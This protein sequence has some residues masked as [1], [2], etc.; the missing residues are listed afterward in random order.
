MTEWKECRDYLERQHAL[1]VNRRDRDQGQAISVGASPASVRSNLPK[2]VDG[3]VRFALKAIKRVA[4]L[5][6]DLSSVP[7]AQM[8]IIKVFEE[9]HRVYQLAA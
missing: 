3:I 2:D 1:I 7:Q 4:E 6:K 5:R 8:K 9:Q